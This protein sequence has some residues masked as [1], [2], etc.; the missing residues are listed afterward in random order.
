MGSVKGERLTGVELSGR[1]GVWFGRAESTPKPRTTRDE[2]REGGE[3]VQPCSYDLEVEG[4]IDPTLG[5]GERNL[6][7]RDEEGRVGG[8][9]GGEKGGDS[10]E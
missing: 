5:V 10:E 7:V 2:W 1:K 3:D 6:L 8:G 9:G 4:A